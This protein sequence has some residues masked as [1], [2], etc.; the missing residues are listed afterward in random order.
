MS[1]LGSF[2]PSFLRKELRMVQAQRRFP[3]AAY[4]RSADVSMNAKLGVKVGIAPNVVINGG[5]VLGD[6]SYV[7][8]GA[9]LFSGSIGRFCSIAHYSQIGAEQHPARHISTSPSIYGRGN[10]VGA[11]IVVDEFPCPPAIGSDV[12]IGSSAIVLQGV[13]IGHGAIVAAGAVV[14]KDVPPFA[15]VGGVPAT[16]IGHRFPDNVVSQLL[17]MAWWDWPAHRLSQLEPLVVAGR[18]F[19]DI[20]PLAS[21]S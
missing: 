5:V 16:Q 12:W 10:V 4:I 3:H 8:M 14:T 2:V 13:T 15:I 18:S 19:T 7:N 21:V 20:I 17:E 11:D 6:Y 9:I 1:R